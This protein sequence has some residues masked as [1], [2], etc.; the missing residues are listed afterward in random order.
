MFLRTACLSA[1]VSIAAIMMVPA[2][3]HAQSA[4]EDSQTVSQQDASSGVIVVTGI[5]RS[6][7][8]AQSIKRNSDQIVDSVVAEDIG[9]LPDVTA[10]ESLARITGIQVTRN[11]GIAQG[12]RLRGLPNL[13]TTYDGRQ[14][15]TGDGRAVALQDFP[16][17]LIA[18]IDVY[19]SA[20][21][22][23]I[24]PGIAG[25]IDVRSHRPFDF[26]G[27]R[28]AGAVSGVHWYQ[29][30]RL[31][32]SADALASTRWHTGIGDMGFLITGSYAQTK[33]QDP[34]R[35]VGQVIINRTNVPGYEGEALRY[36][37]FVNT[38]YSAG[39][40]WR[41]NLDIAFQWQASPT[42]QIYADGLFQ[43]YRA[44]NGA[45][46]FLVNSGAAA[47]LSNIELVP[48]TNQIASMDATGGGQSVGSQQVNDQR[49]NTYQAGGGF[50]W[51][52][53]RLKVT[54]DAAY[55]EST[56]TNTN[57]VFKFQSLKQPTRHYEFDTDKGAG[58]GTVT[59]TNFDVS[60]PASFRWMNVVESGD[61][62]QGNS[63][64]A[65]L[66]L[67]YKL[68]GILT[69]LE[70]GLRYST[71]K[72]K[73]HNYA[74]TD[75]APAHTVLTT[76]PLTY[77]TVSPGLRSD[78]ADTL[79]VWVGP[80]R[81]SLAANEHLLREL[82][83]AEAPTWGDPVFTGRENTYTGYAQA[84]YSFDVGVPVDG[85]I[86]VRATRTEDRINGIERVTS[87]GETT[88]QS[89]SK[90]NSYT[91][92]L[93]N[94]SMRIKFDPKLQLRL[95]FT[96]TRSR[97][98]FE[99]L[100]PSITIGASTSCDSDE[101][102]QCSPASSGNPDLKP[103]RA[104]NYDASLEYY[105]SRDG[106]VTVGAFYKDLTG[107]INNTTTII[108]DPDY[109]RLELSRPE[110][111]GK[112]RIKG[113]EAGARTFFRAPWLP[114]WLSN[115]GALVNFTY[116]DH[117]S[118]LSPTL[119]ETLPGMQPIAGVSKYLYNVSGF[120]ENRHLSLRLSYNHRSKFVVSYGQVIDPALGA[121]VLGPTLPITQNAR[122]TLDFA[123]T[124]SP[125][126]HITLT[127]NATNLL[128]AVRQNYRQY[129]AAGQIYPFQTTFLESVYRVGIRFRF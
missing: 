12:V 79:R 24:G 102:L 88:V 58:G 71:H 45:H 54:G 22:D 85:L 11:A 57:F 70:A 13:A 18:R 60:D 28:I 126:K 124:L 40:R 112:G 25:L 21:A 113:I 82:A 32:F 83:G 16:S 42:L 95:A 107:F 75:V 10:A 1:S 5:R 47:T 51:H 4:D 37:P 97:P 41:P 20:S 49:T 56:F 14:V 122:G 36:P 106:A 80:T 72:A 8:S 94:V 38:N 19:K 109:G 81:A 26:K 116:L 125:A 96:K 48:G 117:K 74:Q 63:I 33:F 61:H 7:E 3:A 108:D 92:F 68:D 29:S 120:Y 34:T 46:N 127:F 87:G 44:K 84:R 9:K 35:A 110:N 105:F 86:G 99:S 62:T 98:S 111:G 104:N 39:T 123:G 90:N 103:V 129:N 17:N 59:I 30:Q 66:D 2:A 31:G 55:T 43:G 101:T 67:D 115:F 77:Q 100:S 64:Q 76:L 121:G 114:D 89:I 50:I 65:R 23:L 52:K 119:A 93:P 128:G 91:D 69:D 78:D 73:Q 118:E 15:F 27:T 53:G 6:F